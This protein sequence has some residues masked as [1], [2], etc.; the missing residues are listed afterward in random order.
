MQQRSPEGTVTSARP[1]RLSEAEARALL[2]QR[3][4]RV[5]RPRC[6]LLSLLSATTAHPTV[7]AIMNE[8]ERQGES[9]GVATIYQ[10]LSV[11]ASSGLLLRFPDSRGLSR[12][13][14]SVVPHS[15]LICT[16]CGRVDDLAHEQEDLAPCA[17]AAEAA[18]RGGWQVHPGWLHLFG[19]CPTCCG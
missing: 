16:G 4:L 2:R 11:L 7:E 1:Q 17:P 13:D 18:P 5:T 6:V 8:L 15:H 3:G 9:I 12:F 19:L 10:N 14:A